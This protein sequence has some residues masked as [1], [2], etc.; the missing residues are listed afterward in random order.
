MTNLRFQFLIG[1]LLV[2]VLLIFSA[3]FFRFT[4]QVAQQ[5]PA[6][7]VQLLQQAVAQAEQN[8][9]GNKGTFI[10]N[11]LINFIKNTQRNTVRKFKKEPSPVFTPL[12]DEEL[13]EG[14][15][16][17]LQDPEQSKRVTDPLKK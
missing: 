11:R 7:S 2:T 3:L 17:S 9:K 12:P 4:A 10:V 15:P 16:S 5:M 6:E 13:E 8:R 1:L 14:I